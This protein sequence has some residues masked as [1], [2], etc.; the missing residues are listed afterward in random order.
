MFAKVELKGLALPSAH[1]LD[2]LKRDASEQVLEGASDAEA[3][4]FKAGK[5]VGGGDD[6]HAFYHF[7]LGEGGEGL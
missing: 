1:G 4:A 7:P 3:V 6:F 2:Y 5:F